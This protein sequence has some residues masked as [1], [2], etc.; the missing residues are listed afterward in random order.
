MTRHEAIPERIVRKKGH[1]VIK[2]SAMLTG[3]TLAGVGA[4]A[5]YKA[6]KNHNIKRDFENMHF[7]YGEDNCG[8]GHGGH[9]H[10]GHGHHGV[11]KK[12]LGHYSD[13]EDSA[14]DGRNT[15]SYSS[16]DHSDCYMGYEACGCDKDKFAGF[17]KGDRQGGSNGGLNNMKTE[18]SSEDYAVLKSKVDKFNENHKIGSAN[19]FNNGHK[20]ESK[21]DIK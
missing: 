9:H 6:V 7:E 12:G 21:D 3:A 19:E 18:H 13:F 11:D 10:H 15:N 5:S 8:C 4:Y 14:D 2:A 20:D 16:Y 1:P 17:H